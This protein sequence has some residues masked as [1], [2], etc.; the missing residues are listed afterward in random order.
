MV[1]QSTL[2]SLENNFLILAQN[3]P[4]YAYL[5]KAKLWPTLGKAFKR[6][7]SEGKG[8]IMIFLQGD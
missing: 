7:T 8:E 3:D 4:H 2:P 5:A 6:K 1:H